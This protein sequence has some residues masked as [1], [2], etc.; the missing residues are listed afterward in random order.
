[1]LIWFE[2]TSQKVFITTPIEQH[3]KSNAAASGEV[4]NLGLPICTTM[5][6][7]NVGKTMPF[8]PSPSHH[9]E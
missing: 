6:G 2:T 8:A 1:M 4:G 3:I 9:P 7:V 5:I